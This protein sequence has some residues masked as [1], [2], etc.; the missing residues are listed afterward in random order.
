[1]IPLGYRDPGGRDYDSFLPGLQGLKRQTII[2]TGDGLIVASGSSAPVPDGRRGR[3]RRLLKIGLDGATDDGYEGPKLPETSFWGERFFLAASPEGKTIYLAG[4]WNYKVKG[5]DQCVFRASWSDDTFQPFLGEV[6]VAGDDEKH[7][8]DPRGLAVDAQGHLLVC[9]YRNDRIQVFS[10]QGKFLKSLRITGPEQVIVHPKSG[11]LYVLSVRDRGNMASG[12]GVKWETIA[13]KS[14]IKYR[15]VDDFREVARL[16]LPQRE[17]YLHDPGPVLAL[18]SAASVPILWVS[19]V[20]RAEPG[21]YLWKIED[22][23]DS[24]V[25]LETPMGKYYC[26]FGTGAG[27][28]AVDA[29][30]GDAY[31]G[32]RTTPTIFRIDG[33]TGELTELDQVANYIY[34]GDTRPFKLRQVTNMTVDREGRLYIRLMGTWSGKENWLLRV[35]RDGTPAPFTKAGKAITITQPSHGYH[36]GGM[37][38]AAN[39]DIYVVDLVPGGKHRDPSEHNV[40]NIYAPDGS[41]KQ[42]QAMKWLTSGAWGPRFDS[43]GNMYFTESVRPV[44]Q[45]ASE[46]IGSLIRFS[47]ASPEL[48][49]GEALAQPQADYEMRRYERDIVPVSLSGADWIYFGVSPVPFGHCVCPS[50]P[51]DLDGFDRIVVTDAVNLRVKLLDSA[52]NLMA[53]LGRYSNRDSRGPQSSLPVPPIPIGNPASVANADNLIY[54]FDQFNNRIVRIRLSYQVEELVPVP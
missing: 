49:F 26:P 35:H 1:M 19:C 36:S 22:R 47:S 29:Q 27:A 17:L 52:G 28:L 5:Y 37:G 34:E 45:D 7:F 41:L 14:I 42:A 30:T 53:A 54:V 33:R 6:G 31:F 11:E 9:D 2:L 50:A 44:G 25:Q 10:P 13:D 43:K 4:L 46:R 51:F 3:G 24:L 32:G 40:L 38:I 12:Y 21:D 18:D 16:D 20:G 48:V 39:G 23:G 15:S 8:N